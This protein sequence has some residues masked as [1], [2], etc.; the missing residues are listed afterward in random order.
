MCGK[1][2]KKQKTSS[3]STTNSSYSN[4]SSSTYT[5]N[6]QAMDAYG[7]VLD[8][9]Q[10]AAQTPF[11]YATTKNVA[12]LTPQQLAGYDLI[13]ALQGAFIP[14]LDAASGYTAAGAAPIGTAQINNYMDPYRQQVVDAT[15]ANINRSN[16]V[17]QQ[18]V[19]GNAAAQRALGGNRV[20]IAQAE[21]AR[22]QDLSRDKTIA[23]LLSGGFSQAL[24]AA[25]SDSARQ[26]QA[27]TQF[28]NLGTLAQT[29]G[30]QGAESLINAGGQQQNFLQSLYDAA[31]GNQ[32]MATMW[33]LQ[34]AQWLAGITSG[35]GP[36]MGGTT[37]STSSGTGTSNTQ[38]TQT[39]TAS[40]GKGAGNIIG[41][42]LT[43]ASMFSD[44]RMKEDIEPVGTLDDGQT[45][46]KYRMK[47][48]PRFQIG[49]LAQE[50][51]D[52]H[53][54]AVSEL[55]GAKMVNYDE[56][57]SFADG[58]SVEEQ[59][60]QILRGKQF[61][62]MPGMWNKIKAAKPI[63]PSVDMIDPS[64]LMAGSSGMG[65]I[66]NMMGDDSGGG[67]SFDPMKSINLGKSARAGI[68]NILRGLDPAGG[69]GASIE[70]LSGASSGKGL[71]SIGSFF[72]F[73]DGGAVPRYGDGGGL[74]DFWKYFA[75][76][77][78]GAS[79][80][81]GEGMSMISPIMGLMG[82]N[83]GGVGGIASLLGGGGLGGLLGMFAEGGGVDEMP[84]LPAAPM[85][86]GT[87]YDWLSAFAPGAAP[88]SYFRQGWRDLNASRRPGGY[89]EPVFNYGGYDASPAQEAVEPP[90]TS[91]GKGKG[92]GTRSGTS[93][94]KGMK[95]THANGGPVGF[96]YGGRHHGHHWYRG[97][98]Q[99]P[100]RNQI[101]DGTPGN[102]AW[103]HRPDTTGYWRGYAGEK[104]PWHENVPYENYRANP[105]GEQGPIDQQGNALPEG[106][107]WRGYWNNYQPYTPPAP[108][109]A[110]APTP[111]P[112][113]EPTSTG[114]GKGKGSSAPR[115]GVIGL[116]KG[117]K[118]N[119]AMGGRAYAG[120]GD[121]KPGYEFGGGLFDLLNL[122]N[123]ISM[124][125]AA[126]AIQF[127]QSTPKSDM[128]AM[129]PGVPGLD[130]LFNDVPI[131][132]EKT[133]TFGGAPAM[134]DSAQPRITSGPFDRGINDA[135]FNAAREYG[136]SPE[137]L[138]AFARIESSGDPNARTGSYHGLFQL[139][140]NEFDRY[141]G[142]DIYNPVD[143]ANAAAL[144]LKAES[145]DFERKYG[146]APEPWELYMTHQQGEGGFQAH[147]RNPEGLAWENMASTA[148]GRQ[149]GPA[150]AKAA[151]WGNVPKDARARYGSVDNMTS[152]DFLDL[153]KGKV[154]RFRQPGAVA[155]A[156]TG[157]PAEP[158]AFGGPQGLVA[159]G[160][161]REEPASNKY[162]SAQDQ[163]TGGLLKRLFGIDFNPLRLNENERMA[164][165]SAGL[166]M[167]STGD[168]GRGGLAGLQY[169]QGAEK[170]QQDAALAAQ[171]LR[172]DIMTKLK[173]EFKQVGEDM[174]GG[175]QYG[176]VD[177]FKGT[178]T[179][180]KSPGGEQRAAEEA[181]FAGL[182]GQDLISALPPQI[183][184][185][186]KAIVEGR[187]APPSSFAL[188]SP[189]WQKMLGYA[190]QYEPGFDL[191]NWKARSETRAD[192]SKGR[193]AANI[194]SLNTVMGHLESLDKAIEP[195]NNT[196]WPMLNTALNAVQTNIGDTGLQSAIKSFNVKK[197]AVATELMK[198]FRET[199]AGSVTEIQE[200]KKLIDTSDS[201][202][203]LHTAVQAALDLI[204][205]RMSAVND[206]WNRVFG[207]N[208]PIEEILSPHARE[209]YQRLSGQAAPEGGQKDA[210]AAP[211]GVPAPK[212]QAEYEAIPS[213]TLYLHPDGQT[214]VKP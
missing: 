136:V 58:G 126:P 50:V 79:Q 157:A 181:Q 86:G 178:V 213:G 127:P 162:Q 154:D 105:W 192:F 176:F 99:L 52:R 108:Q 153:W 104:H 111:T 114:K 18:D 38:G 62:E 112:T 45:V 205:S 9:A 156:N 204:G 6:A 53:P 5:P 2:S 151:I 12:D 74:G 47:G 144:K 29:L 91:T 163:Q 150:W 140:N 128:M 183:G 94:G 70:P 75:S 59:I 21:L 121:V 57:T 168:V 84:A 68:D 191:S 78:W 73:A 148:E 177:P 32:Q 93:S 7:N 106:T 42:A 23:D 8:Y 11:N 71:S 169:L 55:G 134:A 170:Q 175:K 203:A 146:R 159:K 81:G 46:Y 82:D 123:P 124:A 206:Q 174:Y 110:P 101:S 208:R 209:I 65:G 60:A 129:A 41:S 76:P 13:G 167:M 198:V 3:N 119:R 179:P 190:S 122:F 142:G 20:G 24:S 77:I 160:M 145:A 194:K 35:I 201:P 113:P 95:G 115:T 49:L 120:G 161:D 30:L 102:Q 48:D 116:G 63:V 130:E 61:G 69:W 171:K 36:L 100:Y 19:I 138:F 80:N 199:G 4:R 147:M 188:K 98:E 31:S 185:Q 51:E 27:G 200:W 66:P 44:E 141:G 67:G 210:Q 155:S 90:R 64:K 196:R 109:P 107:S 88:R 117:G 211:S 143:N 83:A 43:L 214:K 135:I 85:M 197:D 33:P 149:K 212:T 97:H 34:M 56:A 195:L 132:G 133:P 166:T 202:E 152:A 10:S 186:V 187:M 139:S 39:T 207:E 17:Q 193:A 54:E 92:K 14:Y 26:M 28:A 137:D 184:T 118:G 96:N 37:N 40:Q 172:L 16:A 15:L 189:Y 89:T 173:P 165:M 72:G 164:L 25:Q 158:G 22:S 103:G 1:G 182:A 125:E 180:V 87:A 131:M